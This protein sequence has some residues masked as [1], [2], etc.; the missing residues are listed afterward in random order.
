M[1]QLVKSVDVPILIEESTWDWPKYNEICIDI[2]PT[3]QKYFAAFGGFIA[4]FMLGGYLAVGNF[5]PY[6]ASYLTAQQVDVD[7]INNSNEFIMSCTPSIQYMY[8]SN[9]AMCNWLM[10]AFTFGYA[11]F[12]WLGGSLQLY[13]ETRYIVLLG[14]SIV[15]L[16]FMMTYLYA[17]RIST[18]IVCSFGLCYGIA[19]AVAWSPSIVC[20]IRW[21]PAN[22]GK[23]SGI[24]VSG[25]AFG[26]VCYSLIETL[27]INPYD[28]ANDDLCGYVLHREITDKVPKVFI[29]FAIFVAVLTLISF[30]FLVDKPIQTNEDLDT[31][32][33]HSPDSLA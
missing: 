32:S 33:I 1:H 16:Q 12:G 22:K 4:N 13:W 26:S 9:T 17:D 2:P 10:S 7:M 8:A 29:L 30:V 24:L 25:I 19:V 14:G 5:I 3:K 21:F 23:L 28:I 18:I 15:V 6:L 27:Y 20:V 31:L 11:G